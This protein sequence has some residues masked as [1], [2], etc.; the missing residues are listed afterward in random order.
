MLNAE[1]LADTFD[2]RQP[3]ADSRQ[4]TADTEPQ[5]PATNNGFSTSARNASFRFRPRMR[6][7]SAVSALMGTL[8]NRIVAKRS[9][10]TSSPPT[11]TTDFT[12]YRATNSSCATM[13][14][15]PRA[16]GT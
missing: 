15:L 11:P 9:P 12:P 14:G 5:L 13:Y 8:E 16:S 3:T 4:P 1:Q 7:A 10:V 6:K 2:S